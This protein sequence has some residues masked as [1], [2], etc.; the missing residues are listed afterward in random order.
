M[1]TARGVGR[2]G[3]AQVDS[4]GK[5]LRNARFPE[6]GAGGGGRH[7]ASPLVPL[8]RRYK[9][10]LAFENAQ[11]PDYVTEKF[12]IPLLAGAVPVYLGAPNAAD[13]APD[14]HSFVSVR[15]FPGPPALAAHLLALAADPAAYARLHE[16]RRRPPSA[17]WLALAAMAV[18]QGPVYTEV[19]TPH[20]PP[21]GRPPSA[22]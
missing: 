13:L 19:P 10:V 16:W 20:P 14:P 12:Y 11:E 7:P 9:F 6:A 15:D 3:R 2:A 8:M 1:P 17:A 5:C 22:D 21:A 4:Y 18:N